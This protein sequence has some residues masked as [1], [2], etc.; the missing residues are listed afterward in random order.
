MQMAREDFRGGPLNE[1]EHHTVK[2]GLR[3]I[4]E[5]ES[6][7]QQG[8]AIDGYGSTKRDDDRRDSMSSNILSIILDSTSE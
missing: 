8:I 7:L 3:R 1:V 2:E 5:E 6:R 4:I